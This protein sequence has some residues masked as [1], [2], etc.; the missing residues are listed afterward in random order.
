MYLSYFGF[1]MAFINIVSRCAIHVFI[2]KVKQLY[3]W[4]EEVIQKALDQFCECW[5]YKICYLQICS[6]LVWEHFQH[7][8]K[9]SS[10][11]TQCIIEL[12]CLYNIKII[13]LIR[14]QNLFN[15]VSKSDIFLTKFPV[16][17]SY[18]IRGPSEGFCGDCEPAIQPEASS[19]EQV[20]IVLSKIPNPPNYKCLWE[21]RVPALLNKP[22]INQGVVP[23]LVWTRSVWFGVSWSWR[24]LSCSPSHQWRLYPPPPLAS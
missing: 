7:Q 3:I 2:H 12:F 18:K 15:S 8:S 1:I 4:T 19:A 21:L 16:W 13:K 11:R 17:V 14:V 6:S 5:K 23:D 22:V 24:T 9:V 20:L 10:N